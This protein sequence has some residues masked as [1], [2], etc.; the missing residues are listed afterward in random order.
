MKLPSPKPST[1]AFLKEARQ[2]KDFTLFDLIHGYVYLRFPY[3]YISLAKGDHPLSRRLAPVL[4]WVG[5]MIENQ[6]RQ[7]GNGTNSGFADTYHGK[8]MPVQE[9]KQLVSIK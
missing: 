2:T 5:R 3:L 8:V 1:L 6:A 4:R 7:G 9:A